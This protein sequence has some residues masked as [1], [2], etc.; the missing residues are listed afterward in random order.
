VEGAGNAPAPAVAVEE[1]AV[2]LGSGRGGVTRTPI[3]SDTDKGRISPEMGPTAVRRVRRRTCESSWVNRRP[4]VRSLRVRST[5]SLKSL[6]AR[7]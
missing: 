2:A 3:G 1:E 5:H 6:A 7:R 4:L